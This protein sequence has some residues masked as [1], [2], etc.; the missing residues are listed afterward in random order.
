M[1]MSITRGDTPTIKVT[2]TKPDGSEYELKEGDVLTF[3]AK[4]STRVDDPVVIQKTMTRATGPVFRL[5]EEDTSIPYGT[6]RYDVE[7]RTAAGDVHTVVKPDKLKITDEV[8][9]HG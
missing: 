9:T 8:T 4:E 3:T 2:V 1:P 5:G 7:L 6:Y